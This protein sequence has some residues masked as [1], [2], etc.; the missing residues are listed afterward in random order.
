VIATLLLP[1]L[2]AAQGVT[3]PLSIRAAGRIL[4]QATWGPQVGDLWALQSKGFDAWF[5]AQLSAPVS[6]YADQPLLDASGNNNNNLAPVQVQFFQN[7]LSGPDQLRQRV[8]FAL[9]EIWVVSDLDVNNASAFPPLLRIF[10]NRAFDNYE[11]LMKDVS[12]SPAMGRYLNMVNNDKANPAKGTAA[13][14]NYARE[15]MQLFTLGLTKLN[16]DGTPVLDTNGRPVPTYTESDVVN[17]AK[18]FTGWTY[19]PMPGTVTKGH[20]PTY[21]LGPMVPLEI[22][23]DVTAKQ[24]LG[25]TLPAGRTADQDL[26]EALHIVFMQSTLPPFISQQLIEHLVTSNPSPAYIQRVASIF[27]D[28]G[29]GVRGNLQ[30]VVRAILTD[31][32]ARAAD[33]PASTQPA[34]YGHLRE[35]ILFVMNLLRGLGGAVSSTSG[36]ANTASNMSQRLF[37]APSVFS[38]FSPLYRTSGGL[39]G[40]EFQIYST[41]TAANRAD[42]VNSAIYGGKLDAGTTFDLSPFIAAAANP[43]GLLQM[44]NTV[45]FHDAMS[46]DVSSAMTKAMAAV[47]LPSDKAKAA[48]YIALTSSEYQIIH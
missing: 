21:Y 26:T 33:D 25:V 45:F 42:A 40:P 39:L 4:E 3:S 7:A 34:N 17:L 16:L 37:Y 35:P 13:N 12:L 47:T 27:Q 6:T 20:N 31:P 5:Q 30:A 38:Y 10:Q 15:T 48:L 24:I 11:T 1:A 19:P 29:A 23:H 8:A 22:N 9:S 32:E 43:A 14:E 2:G 36:A 41:Q 46:N 44:I 28:D 18:A